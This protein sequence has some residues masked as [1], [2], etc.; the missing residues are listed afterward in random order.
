M[1][2][3]IKRLLVLAF[4]VTTG[5][6]GAAYLAADS[7]DTLQDG[8]ARLLSYILKQQLSNNHYQPRPFDAALADDV[9]TLYLE[10]L[11]PQKRFL[12]QD[13][14]RQ[15]ERLKVSLA[16]DFK[17]GRLTLAEAGHRL[18]LQRIR[19]V[20]PLVL[21]LLATPFDYSRN[22]FFETDADKLDFC[23]DSPALLERWRLALKL[24]ALNRYLDLV[25]EAEQQAPLDDAKRAEFEAEARTKV[26]KSLVGVFKRLLDETVQDH[27]NYFLGTVARAFD[28]HTNYL[29]PRQKEDFDIHMRGSLEGIGASL[30]EE[31]GYIKVVSIIPG[32]AA[33]R[34]GD[35]AAEDLILEVAQEGEEPVDVTNMRLREAVSLIRGPKGTKVRLAVRKPDGQH[36]TISIVRD[37]VQIEETFVKGTLLPPGAH[38]EHYGYIKIPTFYRDFSQ[39]GEGRNS[40]DDM[41]KELQDLSR[42]APLDGLILDLRNNGGGALT[43]AVSIAGLFIASGP[44]VQVRN[45]DGTIKTLSDTDKEIAYSGPMV[46]LVN[47]FS[48][49]ASEILAGALQD[50][51]RALIVGSDHTHGK[52]TVQAVVDLDRH[53]PFRNMQKYLPLGAL[54]VTIQKFYRISGESTQYR[55]VVPDIILPDRQQ[56]LETGER[57]LEHSL[58]W[59][60]VAKTSYAPWPTPLPNLDALRALSRERQ[61]HSADFAEI[62]GQAALLKER[63]EQTLEPLELSAARLE[64]EKTSSLRSGVFHDDEPEDAPAQEDPDAWKAQLDKDAVFGEARDLLDDLIRIGK[65]S[66][67]GAY[68]H[69][70]NGR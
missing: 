3:W 69:T 22:E 67:S 9:F 48:A 14:V 12:L 11:D 56:H 52:G 49:S 25:E 61:Q 18:L 30:R 44:V 32:G 58:P 5:L 31:D 51:R 35:L 37:V 59:D 64:R 21:D 17:E 27:Y 42:E 46:V 41:R 13:D 4:L 39:H 16:S 53:L 55:G 36:L 6:G 68:P 45:G 60:T 33:S 1:Q 62:R 57:F 50:Y 34:Q 40:T 7:S 28:P 19:Q 2:T 15:L 54:M 20:Q 63:S 24:Q 66:G 26:E 43:D 38:G 8:R 29:P 70:A 65:T 47:R 23:T 10:Q